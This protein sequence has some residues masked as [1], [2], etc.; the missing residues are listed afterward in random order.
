VSREKT[1]PNTDNSPITAGGRVGA[2][3]KECKRCAMGVC[4][5]PV[6]CVKDRSFGKEV[7][8]GVAVDW[9]LD[10][11]ITNYPLRYRGR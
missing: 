3:A 10:P 8:V 4:R 6:K 11:W 2:A 1:V 9:V 7:L 5:A